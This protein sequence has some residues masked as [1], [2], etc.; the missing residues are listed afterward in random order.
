MAFVTVQT[1]ATNV[2]GVGSPPLLMITGTY[3]NTGGDT[4][5]AIAAGYNNSSGTFTAVPSQN[6][7]VNTGI[8]GRTILFADFTPTLSDATAPGGVKSYDA[9]LDADVFT[10][11]TTADTGGTYRLWCLDNGQ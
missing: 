2:A 3:L 5:G 11:V 7:I 6:G 8:G 10:V 9:T 4:G 1:N